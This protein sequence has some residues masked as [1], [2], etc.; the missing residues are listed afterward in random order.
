MV[1][2]KV[3]KSGRR[4]RRSRKPQ[5]GPVIGWRDRLAMFEYQDPAVLNQPNPVQAT[6]YTILDS[7]DFVRI[8]DICVNIEDTNETLKPTITIDGQT[9]QGSGVACTHSTNYYGYIYAHAINRLDY[10][11]LGTRTAAQ[12]LAKPA[13]L[14]EGVN[15]KVEIQK[16]TNAGAGNL[17]GIITYGVLK[18]A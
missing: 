6:D 12:L 13:F 1:V 5:L 7:T 8:Y 11:S 14:I 17:T 3:F 2:G 16:T 18:D 10:V 4:A 9:I 15:I